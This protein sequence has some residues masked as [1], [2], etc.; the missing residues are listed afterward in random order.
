MYACVSCMACMHICHACIQANSKLPYLEDENGIEHRVGE[1]R[2][3]VQGWLKRGPQVPNRGPQVARYLLR[4]AELA[5]TERFLKELEAHYIDDSCALIICHYHLWRI[6][7]AYY[8]C[9][10]CM[11]IMH[12]YY[13]CV[14]CMRIMHAYHACVACMRTMHAY[15][16][17]VA[18]MRTMHACVRFVYV[19]SFCF[20]LFNCM[21]RLRITELPKT[22]SSSRW[23]WQSRLSQLA[24][25]TTAATSPCPARRQGHLTKIKTFSLKS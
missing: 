13:A 1:H 14:L 2:A 23:R 21:P 17:C 12:A 24:L 10:L 25:W 19:L 6:M 9:V 8:A 22:A 15:Y 20:F 3:S 16:A 5:S 7:H 18:C 4:A 11:R